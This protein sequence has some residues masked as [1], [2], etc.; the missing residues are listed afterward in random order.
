MAGLNKVSVP[1]IWK[2]VYGI[3]GLVTSILALIFFIAL[4][5]IMTGSF[6]LFQN[7]FI[8]R[9]IKLHAE[10]SIDLNESL[11]VVNLL[12]IS[13]LILIG[14]MAFAFYPVLA[15]INKPLAFITVAQP[16]LGIVLFI[17]TQEAGRTSTF[18]TILTLSVILLWSDEFGRNT[19][20][21]G[22]LATSLLLI[23]NLSFIFIYS[24]IMA[25]I[26]SIGYLL[27]IPWFFLISFT[28]YQKY[29]NFSS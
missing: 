15:E 5:E 20:H 2:Y 1:S 14:M 11:G 16:P 19:S 18:T 25:I 8:L 24:P 21:I 10:F 4:V 12:D 27:I 29:T 17:I 26:M 22:I 7:N 13:I 28:F 23:A 3:G 9:L 6:E